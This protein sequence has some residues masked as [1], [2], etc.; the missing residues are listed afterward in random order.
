MSRKIDVSDPKKLSEDDVRYLQDRQGLPG[1]GLPKG[2]KP[3]R[4]SPDM[5]ESEYQ[6]AAT[7]SA[8]DGGSPPPVAG[9]SSPEEAGDYGSMTVAALKAEVDR[10]NEERDE[11][12]QLDRPSKKSELIEVLEADDFESEE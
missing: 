11:D 4:V 9:T 6:G 1:G 7:N 10:R 8:P 5:E 12:N 3:V 2:A